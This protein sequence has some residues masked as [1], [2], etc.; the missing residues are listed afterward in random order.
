MK[1]QDIIGK[2]GNRS[3]GSVNFV[4][5]DACRQELRGHDPDA[6]KNIMAADGTCVLFASSAGKPAFDGKPGRNGVLTEA[7]LNALRDKKSVGQSH[8]EFFAD[9]RTRVSMIG[10]WYNYQRAE[11][12]DGIV[13]KFIF[14][15]PNVYVKTAV[16]L[17][18]SIRL[19]HSPAVTFLKS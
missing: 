4:V 12:R 2:L 9:V 14:R 6:G 19:P 11:V 8:Q 17:K 1:V 10:K 18:V 7:F 13:G 3:E 5:I 16:E 15:P